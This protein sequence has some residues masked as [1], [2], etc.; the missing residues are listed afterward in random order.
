MR[1]LC[2][3][4]LAVLFAGCA[5]T[6]PLHP[7]EALAPG[8]QCTRLEAAARVHWNTFN[9]IDLQKKA[10]KACSGG[11]LAAC[12][13]IPVAIPFTA[14]IGI[15]G[16]PVLIPIFMASPGIQIAGCVPQSAEAPSFTQESGRG[17]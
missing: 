15:A 8:R 5:A 10:N 4:S 12:C 6:T 13:A 16:A 17:D 14:A 9:P 2:L 3:L 1:R 11:D 7:G